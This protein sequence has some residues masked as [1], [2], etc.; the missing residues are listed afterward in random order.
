MSTFF[1][2]TRPRAATQGEKPAWWFGE[3]VPASTT[4]SGA[5]TGRARMATW[6]GE[7]MPPNSW[8]DETSFGSCS[9]FSARPRWE[10]QPLTPPSQQTTCSVY[11]APAETQFGFDGP[12]NQ[13]DKDSSHVYAPVAAGV[14]EVS[15]FACDSGHCNLEGEERLGNCVLFVMH[16]FS[17]IG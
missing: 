5:G 3:A 14:G 2:L 10:S 8:V 16:V 15:L 4:D 11:C 7:K 1:L 12:S 9:D 6:A 17:I 13:R